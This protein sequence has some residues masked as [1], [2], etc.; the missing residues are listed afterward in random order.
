[1]T[2]CIGLTNGGSIPV[3]VQLRL[4]GAPTGQLADYVDMTVE[5]GTRDATA[6]GPGCGSFAPAASGAEVFRGELDDFPTK[7]ATAIADGGAPLAVGREA[8]LPHHLEL[9]DTEDAEGTS[10]GGVDFRWESSSAG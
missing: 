6:T 3:P 5:R 10:L 4:A 1:V 8:C 9:Q 2:R 7:T